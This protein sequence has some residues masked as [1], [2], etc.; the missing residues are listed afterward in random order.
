MSGRLWQSGDHSIQ[1][2]LNRLILQMFIPVLAILICIVLMLVVRNYQYAS[3]SGN[4]IDASGFNQNFKDEVDLKMYQFVS[5]SSDQLPWDEVRTAQ[6]LA[7]KLLDSTQNSESHK[8]IENVLYLCDSLETSITKIQET[9]RYDQ[10][11]EQLETNIYVITQLIQEHI[12]T[13]L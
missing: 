3:V 12:Y 1:G 8:A 11:M 2:R 4:I 7:E 6:E 5:G 9:E 10:R 13:Y